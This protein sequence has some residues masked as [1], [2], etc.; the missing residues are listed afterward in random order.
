[1]LRPYT[2]MLRSCLPMA[3][4]QFGSREPLRLLDVR[5][6]E[7]VDAETLAQRHGR[8]LP[9]QELGAQIERIGRKHFGARRLRIRRGATVGILDDGNHATAFFSGAFGNQLL[10]PIRE[11]GH[12][13]WWT[14]VQLVTAARGPVG[15]GRPERACAGEID[16][17]RPLE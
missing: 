16:A 6:I 10:E 15:D 7:G 5:L 4:R 14:Q 13:W 2:P 17:A 12:P 8:V 1:M 9:A 11:C 3:A